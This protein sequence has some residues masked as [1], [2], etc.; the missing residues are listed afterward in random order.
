MNR[1]QHLHQAGVSIWLD[2]LSRD[3]LRAAVAAGVRTPRELFFD[4]PP[5]SPTTPPPPSSK[6]CSCGTVSRGPTY[7]RYHRRF[8]DDR[9]RGLADAGAHSQRPLWASTGTK[10]PAYSDVLYVEQLIAPD[11]EPLPPISSAKACAPS[12]TPTTSC[13]RASTRSSQ[14]SKR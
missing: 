5:T 1:L 9:R 3:Q 6:R 2:V 14:R 13:W 7:A 10:N 12:A 11:V 4:A 8:A